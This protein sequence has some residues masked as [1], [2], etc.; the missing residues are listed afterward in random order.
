MAKRAKTIP[1]AIPADMRKHLQRELSA[2]YA[3]LEDL[4]AN[5]HAMNL[6]FQSVAENT[7]EYDTT[8]PAASAGMAV[9]RGA[10]ERLEEGLSVLRDLQVIVM[11][12]HA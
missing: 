1:N 2:A 12:V 10:N 8:E 9:A 7:V 4:F 11:G 6:M 5:L 3:K